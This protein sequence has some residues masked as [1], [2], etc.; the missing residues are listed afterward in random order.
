MNSDLSFNLMYGAN[1]SRT[2]LER[3]VEA[4]QPYPRG[5]YFLSRGNQGAEAVLP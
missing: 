5:Q 2:F 3:V 1:V 4:L